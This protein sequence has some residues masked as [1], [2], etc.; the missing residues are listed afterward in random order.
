VTLVRLLIPALAHRLDERQVLRWAMVATGGVFVLYP[1]A[2]N[3]W[4]M[5]VCAA[6]LGVA[7]GSVQPMVMS[8]LH[9][10]TPDQRHGEALALRSM[11]INASSTAMPLVFGATGTLVGAAVLFWAVGAAVAG[12]AALVRRLGGDGS[13]DAE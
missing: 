10:L 8:M 12:G 11:A 6:L 7:L 4:L 1:L 3:P 13:A 5:A 9:R 2:P